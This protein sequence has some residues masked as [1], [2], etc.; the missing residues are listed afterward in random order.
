MNE[1]IT[2]AAKVL[3][4]NTAKACGTNAD[5]EWAVYRETHIED[6]TAML[7]AADK[8]QQPRLDGAVGIIEELLERMDYP[9][10]KSC[11]CHIS[12]PCNDCVT[13][14]GIRETIENAEELVKNHV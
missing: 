3:C 14:S 7:A 6:A 8:T 13:Y 11:S 2:A 4:A 5:D 1:R 10:E 9:P 12:P